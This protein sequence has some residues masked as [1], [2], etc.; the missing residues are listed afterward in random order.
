MIRR[1]AKRSKKTDPP[2]PPPPP[3]PPMPTTIVVRFDNEEFLRAVTKL[4][5]RQR[6]SRNSTILTLLEERMIEL[7]LWPLRDEGEDDA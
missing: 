7:R 3:P 2:A 5:E 4:S 6:R 1:M